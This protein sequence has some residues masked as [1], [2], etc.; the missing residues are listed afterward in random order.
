MATSTIVPLEVYL[1][2]TYRP[3]ME[4]VDGVLVE[5]NV[6][7]RWHSR[8]ETLLASLLEARETRGGFHVYTEQRIRVALPAR[9]RIPDVCVMARPY[10]A[11]P[12]FTQPP[13]LVIEIASPDDRA[14]DL[15]E[16]VDEYLS[17][18]VA[19]IWIPDPY[20]RRL[21]EASRD[22]LRDCPDLLVK[23]DLVGQVDFGE[24]FRRLDEP[25]D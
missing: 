7:E 22:G 23:T 3:D 13:H 2:T 17:F 18:G 24:L 14:A 1:R 16:K 21:Q 19:H 20:A 5:R 25:S 10:V 15:L 12:V 4:Y 6:G 9:Y 11:E 8:L